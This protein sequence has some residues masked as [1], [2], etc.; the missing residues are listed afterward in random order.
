M[1]SAIYIIDFALALLILANLYLFDTTISNVVRPIAALSWY[2]FCAHRYCRTTLVE[3]YPQQGRQMLLP[4]PL[5]KL[6]NLEYRMI[7]SGPCFQL[8]RDCPA[9]L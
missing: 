6:R 5:L 1:P 7:E 9:D 8:R 3:V 4:S 2:L